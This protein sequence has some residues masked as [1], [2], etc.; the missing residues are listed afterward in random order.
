MRFC[1]AWVGLWRNQQVLFCANL[2]AGGHQ[3]GQK[4]GT[5]LDTIYLSQFRP[6]TKLRQA[7]WLSGG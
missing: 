2:T 3:A 1:H 4:Q 5:N 6:A 7:G